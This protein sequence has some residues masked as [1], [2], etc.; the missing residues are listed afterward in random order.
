MRTKRFT[1][2]GFLGAIAFALLV[3]S[4]PAQA[5]PITI[6]QTVF[7]TNGYYKIIAKWYKTVPY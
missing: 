1:L 7:P 4:T 2:V 3:P 6:T 5:D